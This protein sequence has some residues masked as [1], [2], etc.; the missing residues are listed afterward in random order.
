[1]SSSELTLDSGSIESA[2]IKES[3]HPL[4]TNAITE[5]FI[6]LAM[7]III[8]LMINGLYSFVDAIFI[9]INYCY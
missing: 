4:L 1:M 6:K 2:P 5:Q 9:T 8:A 3:D 7:P